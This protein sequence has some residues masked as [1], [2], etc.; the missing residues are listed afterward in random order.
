M[1]L[2]VWEACLAHELALQSRYHAA[3][4]PSAISAMMT[5]VSV[6]FK[7]TLILKFRVDTWIC[8]LQGTSEG[9]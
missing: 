2:I 1:Q 6:T 8:V 5:K 3:R 7:G 9:Y 4:D